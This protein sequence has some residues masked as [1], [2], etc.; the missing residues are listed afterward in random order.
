MI[1]RTYVTKSRWT[2][3]WRKHIVLSSS[4]G[5]ILGKICPFDEFFFLQIWYLDRLTHIFSQYYSKIR[6]RN[7]IC[8]F[9][10]DF[11]CI[12]VCGIKEFKGKMNICPFDSSK[13]PIKM[14]KMEK[15]GLF[16]FS[17]KY[18]IKKYIIQSFSVLKNSRSLFLHESCK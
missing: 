18:L 10:A 17:K 8:P 3:W 13:S 2:C 4:R 6:A 16:R 12:F 7:N 15:I 14:P 5:H 11:T 1:K 9:D